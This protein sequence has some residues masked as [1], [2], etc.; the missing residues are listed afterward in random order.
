M[1]NDGGGEH[2]RRETK[3]KPE[4]MAIQKSRKGRLQ[5]VKR[6]KNMVGGRELV[7]RKIFRQARKDVDL[8]KPTKKTTEKRRDI[9]I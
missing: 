5:K 7:R 3:G 8:E 4:E 2:P 6:D 1:K 9:A